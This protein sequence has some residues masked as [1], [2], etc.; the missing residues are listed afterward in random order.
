[1]V[2]SA[3]PQIS[4]AHRIAS[5]FGAIPEV[6]AVA[7]SGS[8]TSGSADVYSDIDLVVY[9]RD[10]DPPPEARR[11]L[12]IPRSTKAEID[13]HF[14]ETEDGW[15]ERDSGFAVDVVYRSRAFITDQLERVIVHHQASTGYTTAF[16]YNVLNST[17]L[18][19]RTNWFHGL[20]EFAQQ[21]YPEPLRRAIVA[22]NYPVLRDVLSGY[23]GQMRKA[24][25][26]NDLVSVNHRV[27]AFLASYF[28]TL[29]ALNRV[30][31]PGEKRLLQFTE[32]TCEKLPEDWRE[33]VEGLLSAAGAGTE[34][35]CP[36]ADRL[37]DGLY[38]FLHRERLTDYFSGENSF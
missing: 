33:N 18:F 36:R 28:D 30:L 26:R 35:V 15:I 16:W 3:T 20:Q 32:A 6:I 34:N 22:K 4:V 23:V 27:A 17:L 21:P 7:L 10:S 31:H 24:V 12:I 9:A 29:F 25:F 5:E 19:D 8:L 14:W 11:A 1:M 2:Q 13:N 38:Q 37:T